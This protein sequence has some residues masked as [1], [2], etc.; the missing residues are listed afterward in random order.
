MGFEVWGLGVVFGVLGL[1]VGGVWFRVWE[2]G[3]WGLRVWGSRFGI[4]GLGFAWVGLG[5]EVQGLGFGLR[6]RV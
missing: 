3:I 5:L 1:A 6:F 4:W 2:F